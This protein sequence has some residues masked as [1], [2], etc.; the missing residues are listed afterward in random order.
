MKYVVYCIKL[1]GYVGRSVSHA[2]LLKVGHS[3]ES[4]TFRLSMN[5]RYEGQNSYRSLFQNI[6]IVAQK[7]FQTKEQ[8]EAYEANIHQRLGPKDCSIYEKVSGVKELRQWTLEREDWLKEVL[9]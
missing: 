2:K 9:S 6:Q 1:E 4:A 5:E 7:E 3:K 8:A